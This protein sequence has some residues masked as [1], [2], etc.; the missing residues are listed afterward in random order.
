MI[1]FDEVGV[2]AISPRNVVVSWSIVP[3]AEPLGNYRFEVQRSNDPVSGFESVVT[4]LRNQFYYISSN[5]GEMSKWSTIYY[6]IV[7]TKVALDGVAIPNETTTSTPGTIKGTLDPK[8]YL[9]V[10][11][12]LINFRH[13]NIGRETLVYRRR[14]SGQRCPACWDDVEQLVT[15]HDCPTCFGTGQLGG[16]YPPIKVLIRYLPEIK[17]N[18][19][20]EQLQEFSYTEAHMANYPKVQPGDILFEISAGRWFMVNEIEQTEIGR[21]LVSQTLRL[22]RKDPQNK[23]QDL[24]LPT[25]DAE[26]TIQAMWLVMA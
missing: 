22:R 26:E 18:T 25:L 20:G 23:E 24:P 13:L 6:R 12:K 3:T 11:N 4:G 16:Y 19:T 8:T 7:A 14:N 5:P 2:D 9:I 17:R 10:Q 15:R 21:A 1:R